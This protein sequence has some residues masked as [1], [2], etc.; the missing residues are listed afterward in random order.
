[1]EGRTAECEHE[2]FSTAS[3]I[4]IAI[5]N[6][7]AGAFQLCHAL[8]SAFATNAYIH[9]ENTTAKGTVVVSGI[10]GNGSTIT[11][12]DDRG[13]KRH[14]Q[15]YPVDNVLTNQVSVRRNAAKELF[16]M[17]KVLIVIGLISLTLR[18]WVDLYL[19]ALS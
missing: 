9:I 17:P 10:F 1:V 2:G 19:K 18:L 16:D 15:R 4:R 6:P 11:I 12:K 8:G 14:G 3:G 13:G 5:P 7:N